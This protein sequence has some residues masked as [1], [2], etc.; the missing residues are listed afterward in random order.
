VAP[1]GVIA[2][3]ALPGEDQISGAMLTPFLT[4]LKTVVPGTNVYEDRFPEDYE[5]LVS[6]EHGHTK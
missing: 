2:A 6:Q 5:Y 3:S 4:S 1:T